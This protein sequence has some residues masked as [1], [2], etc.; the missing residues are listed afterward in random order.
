MLKLYKSKGIGD[1]GGERD[2]M[3]YLELGL[4]PVHAPLLLVIAHQWKGE[5]SGL[6]WSQLAEQHRT[7]SLRSLAEE[8]G[9]SHEAVRRALRTAVDRNRHRS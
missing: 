5:V 9:V 6:V 7:R 3:Q 2:Y 8:Y 1:P 4:Y